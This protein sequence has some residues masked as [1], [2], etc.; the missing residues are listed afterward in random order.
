M[1]KDHELL[2]DR[3]AALNAFV[4]NMAMEKEN[5]EEYM[6]EEFIWKEECYGKT[7]TH[8]L[9]DDAVIVRDL[10][11]VY[12]ARDYTT[13]YSQSYAAYDSK[14]SGGSTR[15][16][17]RFSQKCQRR[18]YHEIYHRIRHGYCIC[19]FCNSHVG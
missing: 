15:L 10:G 14:K 11:S 19:G 6:T 3:R 1:A 2:E 9:P 8:K 4:S 12:S 17:I 7:K 18:M 5:A 13:Y 16:H